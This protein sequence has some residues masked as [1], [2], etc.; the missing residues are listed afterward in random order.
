MT[1]KHIDRPLLLTAVSILLIAITFAIFVI[2][3]RVNTLYDEKYIETS[4]ELKGVLEIFINEKKAAVS[5][6]SFALLR[7]TRI[8]NALIN[9]STKSLQLHNFTKVLKENT[10]LKNVWIQIITSDGKSLYR[11]WSSK[12]DDDLSKVRLDVAEGIKQPKIINSI[13]VGKFDL[14][15]KSMIPVYDKEVF[16]GFIE[17]IA[18]FNSIAYKM[19]KKGIDTTILVDKSYKD[20]LKFP[21]TKKFIDDYYVA[22][23]NS[24]PALESFIQ[25]KGAEHF[26]SKEDYHLAEDIKKLV[27]VFHLNNINDRPMSYFLLFMDLD[28]ID[29]S[30]I[31]R[32]RDRLILAAGLAILLLT[33]SFYYLYVKRYRGFINK[34][35]ERLEHEVAS[36][37]IELKEKMRTSNI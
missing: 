30:A 14:T 22:N 28:K 15:F 23:T 8:K 37:T 11:S 20:Q 36:K 7:D 16:I 31:V 13:S 2:S 35:N 3:Y 4:K 5:L 21:F 6:L 25:I 32:I 12:K 34:V 24:S 18:K 26:T 1:I 17:T 29:L 9:R 10:E 27:T 19:Q 33:S